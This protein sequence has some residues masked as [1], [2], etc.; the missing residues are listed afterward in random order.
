MSTKIELSAL[1]L[2]E[3]AARIRALDAT[4]IAEDYRNTWNKAPHGCHVYARVNPRTGET[5]SHIAAGDECSTDEYFSEHGAASISTLISS[6]RDHWEPSP[7]DGYVWEDCEDGETSDYISNEA[8]DEWMCGYSAER[9]AERLGI[10][11]PDDA[12][13]A[14]MLAFMVSRHGWHYFDV[15]YEPIEPSTADEDQIADA[16][17]EL[18]KACEAEAE[19]SE[20]E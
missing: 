4:A 1:E 14:E 16:I 8:G 15:S 18:A 12:T 20:A 9:H 11:L 6:Q 7:E 19:V 3:C 17:E 2:R 13:E 5:W 10:D